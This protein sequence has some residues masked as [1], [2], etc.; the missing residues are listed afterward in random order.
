MAGD[1][2]KMRTNLPDDPAVIGLVDDLGIDTDSVIGKL[3]R[4]WVWADTHTTD[5]HAKVSA[6]WVDRHTNQPGFAKVLAQWGWLVIGPNGVVFPKFDRHNGKSAKTRAE[7]TERQ[8]LSRTSRDK[9]VTNVARKCDA[10]SLLSSS[11]ISSSST[12]GVQGDSVQ[13]SPS[14]WEGI[15]DAD[16]A[17]WL[18]AYPACDIDRQLA[19][20]GEWLK[21]NPKKAIKSN[22]RRFITNWLSRS[23]DHGGDTKSNGAGAFGGRTSGAAA[24]E[25]RR[26]D[27]RA[28]EFPEP[29]EPLPIV[30]F[31]GGAGNDGAGRVPKEAH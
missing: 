21:A 8:R 28:R 30:R 6:A 25:V 2:I 29:D 1:W 13:W 24:A 12:K 20:M 11:L 15:T 26:A 18:A 3:F 31:G 17:A 22:Y 5:G 23:Q 14:G 9:V 19:A 10:S 4:L 16:K 7:N 27:K